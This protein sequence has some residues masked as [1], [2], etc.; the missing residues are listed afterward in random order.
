MPTLSQ[1]AVSAME[2]SKAAEQYEDSWRPGYAERL[3]RMV[4]P[5]PGQHVLDLCCGTGLCLFLLAEALHESNNHLDGGVV[6]GIDGS[7]E[8]LSVAKAKCLTKPHLRNRIRLLQHDVT[9]LE[10][11]GEPHVTPN[12]YDTIVCSCSFVLFDN[13]EAVVKRWRRYLKAPVYPPPAHKRHKK[14]E[15]AAVHARFRHYEP[16]GTLVVDIP[17]EA[18]N[19]GE[20]IM[21]RVARRL[22]LKFPSNRS[23][24]KSVDSFREILER[25]GFKV[26]RV[27]ELDRVSG[28]GALKYTAY[29]AV[30][31]YNSMCRSS[32]FQTMVESARPGF[33]MA[34][35]VANGLQVFMEEF[36]RE[37]GPDGRVYE[38]DTMYIYV[39]RRTS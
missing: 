19:L 36:L 23:W 6:I 37:V 13:P 27:V 30:D 5:K 31:I 34:G 24:V 16:G 7:P 38:S 10:Q 1:C 25:N 18:S 32:A 39:A 20:V 29:M 2:Y 21:E 8:M 12:T 14:D 11:L 22:G 9:A 17:H 26:E 15:S 28:R 3:M 4:R 35:V 33:T